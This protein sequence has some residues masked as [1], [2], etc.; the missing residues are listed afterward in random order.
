MAD[1]DI[2]AAE[3]NAAQFIQF[4]LIYLCNWGANFN[5]AMGGPAA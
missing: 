3:L 1:V 2:A 5:S 4:A